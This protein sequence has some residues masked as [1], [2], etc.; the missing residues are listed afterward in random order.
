MKKNNKKGF[1]IVELVVVIAVIGIL[2]AVLIPTF[3]NIIE[4][5]NISADT[6]LC[7]NMNTALSTAKADG[8]EFN[9]MEDV[10]F[11]INEA[12]YIIEHLNPTTEGYYYAWDSENDQIVFLNK[13]LNVHYPTDAN[14]DPAKCWITVKSNNEADKVVNLR[15]FNLY[16]EPEFKDALSLNELV[17]VDAGANTGV[18]LIIT[19]STDEKNISISG[20]FDG[21][22]IT[23]PKAHVEQYGVAKNVS[24]TVS[25]NSFVVNGYVENVS[26][27]AGSLKVASNGIVKT[28]AAGTTVAAKDGLVLEGT[29]ANVDDKTSF[30]ISNREELAMFRDIVNGG[31]NYEG[32]TVKLT[33][34]INLDGIAWL[35][36][37]NVYRDNA[38]DKDQIT[39][40]AGIFDGQN[41]T[42]KNLSNNGF[43]IDGLASGR[44]A[45][46]VGTKNEVVFG[47]FGCVKNAEIMNLTVNADI[48]DVGSKYVGDS[49]AAIVGYAYGDFTMTNCKATGSITGFDA[50]GGLVG[51]IYGNTINITNCT[52]EAAIT[53]RGTYDQGAKCAGVIGYISAATRNGDMQCV[54]KVTMANCV[55]NGAITTETTRKAQIV[56]MGAGTGNTF[57]GEAVSKTDK[58]V[59]SL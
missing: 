13:K 22:E 57:N 21:V 46:S 27:T 10:L 11:T 18:D 14:I 56:Y 35:P 6:Q 17:S 4:K 58:I 15:K 37:G 23:A 28:V 19:N 49:V 48:T 41:H 54:P 25:A 52:N 55:N 20:N 40:F 24:G 59:D 3:S 7:R 43:S 33:A 9:N 8:R 39:G 5:A 32:K 42:I 38:N 53:A 45:T 44:N 50:V 29:E 26:L 34:D 36:I 1:T 31:Y 16:L 12:G 30:T 51:R 47:L 2:A